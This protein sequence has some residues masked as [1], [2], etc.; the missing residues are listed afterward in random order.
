VRSYGDIAP[1]NAH[2]LHMPTHIFVRL[3]TWDEVID[4]NRRAAEAALTQRVGA[5][6]EYV[7][8]E[9]PHAIEYMVYAHLQQGDDSAAAAAVRNLVATAD[10]QPSFKTAFH[11]AS[12]ASR[13]ALERADWAGAV[14]VPVRAPG[15]LDWDLFPWPE[16]VSW[17]TRGL[18]GAHTGADD[19]VVESLGRLADLQG[20]ATRSGEALF[21]AQI[22]ILRLEVAAWQA[23]AAGDRSGA[24]E[25]LEEAVQLEERTP[26]HPVTPGP[27]IPAREFL[28]D[29]YAA[30][31][32][33]GPARDAYRAS[34]NRAPGRFNTLLGLARSSA[35][36]GDD[37][38]ARDYYRALLDGAVASSTRPGV[39]EARAFLGEGD[40]GSR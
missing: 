12:T 38:A 15:S 34:N 16:A 24:L 28:G 26:K 1:A 29:L 33:P 22:E 27:T 39:L 5:G 11:H 4:W 23:L 36:L 17:H 30:L 21:A 3:G 35:A 7:W 40:P 8:D 10:L 14:G 19:V 37:R 13:L 6:G 31:G 25:R 20:R 18:G 9:F 32:E 2:A